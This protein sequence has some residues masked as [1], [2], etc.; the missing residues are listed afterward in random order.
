MVRVAAFLVV[1]CLSS[2]CEEGLSGPDPR[3]MVDARGASDVLYLPAASTTG[4]WTH[5]LQPGVTYRVVIEGTVSAWRSGDWSMVCAGRPYSAPEFPSPGPTGPVGLDAEW[6]WAY[7][8][9][10]PTLCPDGAPDAPPP[11]ARRL[12]LLRASSGAAPESL[13]PPLEVAMTETHA[14]TYSITGTG[15]AVGFVIDDTPIEDNYGELRI[16]LFPRTT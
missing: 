9:V 2:G 5:P 13:P 14:Y 4:V 8:S 15:A 16:L 6:V 12:V 11:K 7:P 3:T 1:A 10:S